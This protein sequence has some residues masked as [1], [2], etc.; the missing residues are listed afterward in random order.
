MIKT[1]L[2]IF[3]KRIDESSKKIVTEEKEIKVAIDT[4]L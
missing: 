4:F 2:P 1:T 3:E